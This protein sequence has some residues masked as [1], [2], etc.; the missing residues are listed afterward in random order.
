M[1]NLGE[2][3]HDLDEQSKSTCRK[4]EK[5]LIKWTKLKL[6]VVFNSTCIREN[7]LPKYTNINLHDEAARDEEFTKDYRMKLVKRQLENGKRKLMEIEEETKETRRKLEEG[8]QDLTLRKRIIDQIE[9]NSERIH[10]KNS[11]YYDEETTVNIWKFVTPTTTPTML[12]K[13]LGQRTF[14]RRKRILKFRT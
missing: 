13:P 4:F 5:C 8:V 3:I 12:H 1:P 11:S 14:C 9:Q 10:Q 2:L 6:N 7:I